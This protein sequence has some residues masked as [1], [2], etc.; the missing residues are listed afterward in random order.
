[1]SGH[2]RFSNGRRLH[3]LRRWIGVEVWSSQESYRNRRQIR[4]T[5]LSPGPLP[6][7][8]QQS[9]R[10]SCDSVCS[11]WFGSS[12]FSVPSPL[13]PQTAQNPLHDVPT[14][15]G[16]RLNHVER[17]CWIMHSAL[18]ERAAA[19]IPDFPTRFHTARPEKRHF[20]EYPVDYPPGIVGNA[21]ISG[22]PRKGATLGERKRPWK[23]VPRPR[24]AVFPA[25]AGHAS[26][27][28]NRRRC[29]QFGANGSGSLQL[30]PFYQPIDGFFTDRQHGGD[31]GHGEHELR[32]GTLG[33]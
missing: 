20:H 27:Q 33:S 18:A 4:Y 26:E 13:S 31:L 23:R 3:L 21:G 32:K 22:D 9:A 12:S 14:I 24:P 16:N 8:A 30:A 28:L 7:R 25:S 10:T 1:M 17:G 15:S 2:S 29:D 19:P 11:G 6:S 5:R